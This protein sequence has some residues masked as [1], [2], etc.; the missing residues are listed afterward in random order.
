MTKSKNVATDLKVDIDF[1]CGNDVSK[2]YLLRV[3]NDEKGR[4]LIAAINKK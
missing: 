3:R 1:H 4:E 2:E